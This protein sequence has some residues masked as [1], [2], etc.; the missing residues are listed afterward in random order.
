MAET[1]NTEH[2][3]QH[4]ARPVHRRKGND[5]PH[6]PRHLAIPRHSFR[7]LVKKIAKD[8][9]ADLGFGGSTFDTLQICAEE[10]L[11]GVMR[12]SNNI[13]IHS[14]ARGI[15]ARDI[16]FATGAPASPPTSRSTTALPEAEEHRCPICLDKPK[17]TLAMPC[18]HLFACGECA[19]K[20]QTRT[21]PICRGDIHD[22][23]DVFI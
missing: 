5:G 2:T 23:I 16:K 3:P 19:G 6:L 18:R 9:G 7:Q 10:H 15:C 4:Q 14:G 20:L 17:K 11:V 12:D 1:D 8:L 13:A 22:T 21:C